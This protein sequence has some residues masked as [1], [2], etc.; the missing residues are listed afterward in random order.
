MTDRDPGT[1]R[2]PGQADPSDQPSLEE[3]LAR[4]GGE[5]TYP[6]TPDLASTVRRRIED[7]RLVPGRGGLLEG[8]LGRLRL[9]RPASLAL[10]ALLVLA[11]TAVAAGL[12]IGGLRIIFVEE[13]PSVPPTV[14]ARPGDAPGAN[15]GLGSASTIADAE[16]AVGFEV[17]LP[18]SPRLGEPDAVYFSPTVADGMVSLVYGERAGIAAGADGVAVLLTEFRADFDDQL[19]KKVAQSGST[20]EQVRI[21]G[22]IGFWISGSPHVFLY[23]EPSG[24]IWEERIRLVGNTLIW[25][26]D[27]VLLRLESDLPREEAIELAESIR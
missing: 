19:V 25:Q 11:G 14:S 6:P 22:A 3:R 17:A 26:R 13:L 2:R 10:V 9:L 18:S 16:Q 5:T 4:L 8:L 24:D 21:G 12:I 15:L 20:V 27:G 7:E 1:A 23:R